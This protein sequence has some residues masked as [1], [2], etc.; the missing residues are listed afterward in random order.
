MMQQSPQSSGPARQGAPGARWFI[1]ILYAFMAVVV[2][3]W[4][5]GWSGTKHSTVAAPA[6]H[7]TAASATT[8]AGN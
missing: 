1:G 8:G 4:A 5:T 7:G 2:G 6:H 3:L